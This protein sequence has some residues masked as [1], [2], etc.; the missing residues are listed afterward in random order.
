M[1]EILQEADKRNYCISA[2]TDMDFK[3]SFLSP[4]RKNGIA[5]THAYTV[6]QVSNA[7]GHQ[8][9]KL[10]NPWGK[11]E[12][13]G[14]W[15]DGS[16]LWTDEL[17]R[18][19][20]VTEGDDGIFWMSFTDFVRE[21]PY[22]FINY[23]DDSHE[24]TTAPAAHEKDEYVF[25]TCDLDA[26]KHNFI[27]SQIDERMFPRNSGYV[28]SASIMKL[29]KFKGSSIEDGFEMIEQVENSR[30]RDGLLQA[31]LEGGKYGLYV[32]VD[33]EQKTEK[34][35]PHHEFQVTRYGPDG[36]DEFTD[37]TIEYTKEQ[38]LT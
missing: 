24:L 26:G 1:F 30:I 14:D 38:L 22:L 10:R 15:C 37:C 27:V 18:E 6:S 32:A 8:L 17:K 20:N 29:V 9:V 34:R 4:V 13:N 3:P 7:G 36:E 5:A 23:Y 25:M 28:Y 31:D 21:L 33:W 12:W 16:S 19:L 11:T 2:G 35:N